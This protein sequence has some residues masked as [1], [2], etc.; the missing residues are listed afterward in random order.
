M[1]MRLGPGS[2]FGLTELLKSGIRSFTAITTGNCKLIMFHKKQFE[3]MLSA[4]ELKR[5]DLA[6]TP[7]C[8]QFVGSRG[9]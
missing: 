5:Q 7:M 8:K 1:F 3:S 4:Y 2:V 9:K 6:I